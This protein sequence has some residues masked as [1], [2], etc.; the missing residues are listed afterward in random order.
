MHHAAYN[1]GYSQKAKKI[2]SGRVWRN[3][4]IGFGANILA[5][6]LLSSSNSSQ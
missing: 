2:K 3:W 4:G 5:V 6:L 1:R